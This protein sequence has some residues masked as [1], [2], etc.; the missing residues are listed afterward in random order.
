MATP[1]RVSVI[2]IFFNAERFL[3]EAVDRE[4][5]KIG[6]ADVTRVSSITPSEQRAIR[7]IV[8]DGFVYAFRL[9][10]IGAVGV[11]VGSPDKLDIPDVFAMSQDD[12][13]KLLFHDPEKMKV[14]QTKLTEDELTIMFR[15]RET[16]ALLVWEPWM[17]NPKL[18]HRLHRATMPALFVRGASDGLVSADYMSAYAKLVPN[19]RTHTIAAAGHAPQLEQPQALASAVLDFLEK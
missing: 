19:A 7:A 8:D 10:M 11:K 18:K 1:P 16:L 9:V 13:S 5:R 2:T 6:G 3:G 15:N 12:A 17:H 4:L 14:D